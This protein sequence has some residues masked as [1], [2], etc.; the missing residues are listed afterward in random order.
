MINQLLCKLGMIAIYL[1]IP[2]ISKS[3]Q[4]GWSLSGLG[5]LTTSTIPNKVT[6]RIFI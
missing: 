5:S 2:H 4:A 1:L 3:I 6:Y